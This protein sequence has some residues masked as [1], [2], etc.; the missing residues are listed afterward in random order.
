MGSSQKPGSVAVTCQQCGDQ[1]YR[2]R[3]WRLDDGMVPCGK[4]GGPMKPRPNAREEY[5]IAKAKR[6]LEALGE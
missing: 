4:C 2:M 3:Q 1:T 6:E 5:R